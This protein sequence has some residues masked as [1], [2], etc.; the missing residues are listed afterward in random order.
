MFRWKDYAIEINYKNEDISYKIIEIKRRYKPEKDRKKAIDE[1]NKIVCDL[2]NCVLIDGKNLYID[3]NKC[4]SVYID[5][6]ELYRQQ[7]KAIII[8]E[9]NCISPERALHI[10]QYLQKIKYAENNLVNM[11]KNL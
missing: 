3:T 6:V 10:I 11:Y 2:L 7:K 5:D 9:F 8:D 1:C 4:V